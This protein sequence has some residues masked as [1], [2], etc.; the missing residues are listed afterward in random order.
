MNTYQYIRHFYRFVIFIVSFCI[1]QGCQT[2]ND[3][4]IKD[5]FYKWQTMAETSKGY[6]P[7]VAKRFV[8]VPE[9]QLKKKETA[10]DS[11]NDRSL[12]N[13]KITLRMRDTEISTILR[14]L[15]R[16][17]DMNL[18]LNEKISGKV[19]INVKNAGWDRLFEGIL[20]SH[21]LTYTFDG[22]ILRVMTV[23]DM[24]QD[25]KRKNQK[26]NL[27]ITEPLLTRIVS[28]DY[29]NEEMLKA[30]LERFLSRDN[31]GKPIGSV[32][33][34][35]H[36]NSLIIQAVRV[37]MDRMA[38][39]IKQLDRPIPQILIEAHII[40]TTRDTARE[41]GVQWGGLDFSDNGN[42]SNWIHGGSSEI[43]QTDGSL[44]YTTDSEYSGPILHQPGS[45][46]IVNFPAASVPGGGV[47]LTLGLMNQ[48]LGEQILTMQLTALQKDGKLNILSSPSITTLDNHLATIE[49]GASVP[50][51]TVDKNNNVKINWKD[52]VL[53]LEVKPHVIDG[54]TLSLKIKTKKDEL[55]F[56]RQVNG[57]PA[58]VTKKAETNVMLLDGQT[59]VIGGLSKETGSRSEAGVPL[60][61]DIPIFGYFFRNEARKNTM[62]EVLIFITP[63]ILKERLAGHQKIVG[64]STDINNTKQEQKIHNTP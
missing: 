12:P 44:F 30:N 49:S 42:T 55:D 33:V 35:K 10:A 5:D 8:V 54:Q 6:S 20:L 48:R 26:Q 39:L 7:S 25:V 62:E 53:K 37:D 15:A 46:N 28:I 2:R 23:K 27:K 45:G 56:S 21:G 17:V 4:K 14:A 31:A 18:L 16:S 22:E 34:D 57:N 50:Y 13:E 29:A 63:H 60:L 19:T 52:A 43:D 24:E 58:I 9:K 11:R 61:K 59:T 38:S 41:L 51:Q 3:V 32:A 40:E 1:F 64:E 36:T 47:G